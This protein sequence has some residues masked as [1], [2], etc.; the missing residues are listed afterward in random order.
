M[1]L[2]EPFVSEI[3]TM[4]QDAGLGQ[5]CESAIELIGARLQDLRIDWRP[6]QPAN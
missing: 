5:I 4:A 3:L 6:A 2:E 1:G